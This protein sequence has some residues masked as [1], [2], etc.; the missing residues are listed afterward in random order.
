VSVIA[1]VTGKLLK[2]PTTRA[3]KSGEPF[4]LA[5]M[6][7]ATDDGDVL[8]NVIAFG[9]AGETL[10][11]LGAGDAVSVTGRTKMNHWTGSDGQERHGLSLVADGVLTPYQVSVRK[12]RASAEEQSS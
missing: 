9:Q 8:V 3:G 1:L 11:A 10:A 4:T 6:K 5:T 12:R 7:A 2:A